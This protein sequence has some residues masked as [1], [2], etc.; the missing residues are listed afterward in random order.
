MSRNAEGNPLRIVG[1]HREIT[2]QVQVEES[3]RHAGTHDPLTGLPNRTLFND[4]L[5]LAMAQARRNKTV[6]AVVFLDL[7]DFKEINDTL[8]HDVGDLLLKAVAKRLKKEVREVDTVARMGGDE[9]TLILPG[10]HDRKD[11]EQVAE[12][13][14]EAVA[15]PYWLG[16]RVLEVSASLGVSLYPLDGRDVRTL[17]KRAD[18]AMYRAKNDG[19]NLWR[20]WEENTETSPE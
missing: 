1:T 13:I 20:F 15:R 18:M 8:G 11:A 4:H 17:M 16:D 14:R 5:L 2:E 7:D 6:V 12:R 3:L 19:R 10:L 9:F